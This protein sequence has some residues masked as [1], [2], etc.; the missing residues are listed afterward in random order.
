MHYAASP[1]QIWRKQGNHNLISLKITWKNK[2]KFSETIRKGD[3]IALYAQALLFATMIDN[4][5]IK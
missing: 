2:P 3:D 4:M 5:I 1:V